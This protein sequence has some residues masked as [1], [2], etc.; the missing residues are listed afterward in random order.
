MFDVLIVGGGMVGASLAVALKPLKLK[1]GLIEAYN[2]GV[3]EQ[4]SYDDRSIALSYGSSRIYQGMGIWGKLRS[5]VESIQHIH[6]SDRGHF[7]A[8]RMEATE[9]NVPA[10]GYV[11]ESRVL[12]KLLYD[13]LATGEI[14]LLVPAKVYG[15]E[16][17]ADSVQVQIE[18]NGVVDTLQTRLLVVSDGRDSSVREALGIDSIR[19]EYHQTALIAN[20]TTSE[21]HRN[22]AYER[23]TANGP[24]ALLPL[25]EGRYSLVWTHRDD[26]VAN[27]LQLDDADFLRKLQLEFGYRQGAFTKVGQRAAYPLVLQKAVKEVAGRAVVIGNASHALHP[28]TGQGLNLGLRDV[29]QLADLLA[30]TVLANSDPGA[31]DLLARYQRLREP[32]HQS[33]VRYTDTLVRVFSNDF[34]P[35]AHARAAGLMAVDRI[36]LLRHWNARQ[37]MG[38]RQ[39]QTR[40]ARGLGLKQ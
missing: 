19:S 24:L 31:A 37:G 21:P 22:T 15:V 26:E 36:A 38:V 28:V 6:V 34:A 17:S 11:V 5:G 29:A 14:A 16:Q 39:R 8:A 2:F 13:E 9:E 35:L 10:L 3:A 23:F 7:G 18:R 20:V 1:V 30:E 32:D 12:G 33:V 27:T 40:L 25:T 4:P